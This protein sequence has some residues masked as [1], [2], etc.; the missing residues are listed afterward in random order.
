M[1]DD[2]L[3]WRQE[4]AAYITYA[5]CAWCTYARGQKTFLLNLYLYIDTQAAAQA[6][7]MG[8]GVHGLVESCIKIF[9]CVLIPL[10]IEV[11]NQ[12]HGYHIVLP[13][14]EYRL[15]RWDFSP[16]K[17]RFLWSIKN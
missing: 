5:W 9:Y 1:C 11:E 6:N 13:K 8:R 7:G 3:G 12:R 16:R 10:S 4:C 15:I 17:I 2:G 14:N